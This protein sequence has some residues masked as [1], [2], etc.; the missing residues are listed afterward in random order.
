MVRMEQRKSWAIYPRVCPRPFPYCGRTPGTFAWRLTK[1]SRERG[2]RAAVDTGGP[3]CVWSPPMSFRASRFLVLSGFALFGLSSLPCRGEARL[4]LWP[5][6]AIASGKESE[7]DP[8]VPTVDVHLPEPGKATSS[9]VVVLPGGGYGGISMDFEAVHA[10]RG[11]MGPL[12]LCEVLHRCQPHRADGIFRRRASGVH[13]EH[14]CRDEAVRAEAY[15]RLQRW[16]ARNG[17]L[18]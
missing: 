4:S 14:A 17:W 2:I 18:R 15:E 11:A 3:Q 10:A 8:A 9:A 7:G 1:A 13:G 5:A 16:L 12:P 6:G